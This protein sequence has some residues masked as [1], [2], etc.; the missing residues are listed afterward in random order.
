MKNKLTFILIG[1]AGV[2]QILS[3]S[4]DQYVIQK[5]TQIRK[6][7]NEIVTL[8]DKRVQMVT[9]NLSYGRF[10]IQKN[11][12]VRNLI[13]TKR[14]NDLTLK[15]KLEDINNQLDS[16][17]NLL[18]ENEYL[19]KYKNSNSLSQKEII[20]PLLEN[21]DQNYNQIRDGFTNYGTILGKLYK[22]AQKEFKKLNLLSKKRQIMIENKFTFLVL[23]MICNI[24]SIVFLLIFF[25]VSI[26]REKYLN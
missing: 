25:Y 6:I 12:Q 18:L 20:N 5:E 23:G 21:I 3:I 15:Y 14:L 13:D 22:S 10:Y 2:F 24:I 16:Q 7:D 26:K 11:I 4:F 19:P 8:S 17:L 1:L 9:S